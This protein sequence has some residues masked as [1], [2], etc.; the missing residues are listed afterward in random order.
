MSSSFDLT[1]TLTAVRQ[2]STHLQSAEQCSNALAA[3][4][5]AIS[6]SQD[7]ILE[8]NTLDL[9]I[10]RDMAVPDLVVDWLKLTPERVQTA[11]RI[12]HRLS[13]ASESIAST[14]DDCHTRPVGIV[15]FIYEAFPDLGAIASALCIRT[16]N[17]LVLRGGDEASRTNQIIANI[18]QKALIDVGL[19]EDLIC[20]LDPTDVSRLEIAQCTDIDLI[21]PHGRPSLVEQVLQAAS[22]PTVPSR[23]GNCYLYWSAS[24]NLEKVYQMIVGSHTGTPDAVNRIEKVLLHESIS[25][26]TLNRLLNRLQEDGFILKADSAL[27]LNR[28]HVDEAKPLDWGSAY[29]K[30]AIAFRPVKNITDAISWINTHS[31][32]HA[33]SIATA[34]YAESRLFINKCKSAAIYINACPQF[35]RDASRTADIAIGIS[36]RK[37]RTGGLIGLSQL[38]EYQRIIHEA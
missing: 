30:R 22:V 24:G 29:L 38:R 11:A 6:Q 7:D 36:N 35:V 31:S 33:D 26:N 23:M 28:E 21:I 1:A 20:R 12:F 18:L 5:K 2:S 32:N 4:G 13:V 37:G 3:M 16:G 17:A 34:D 25:E 14:R 9:E 15:A 27:N 10:S 8:A 19:P